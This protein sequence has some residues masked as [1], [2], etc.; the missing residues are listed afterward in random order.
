MAKKTII[1]FFRLKT[2][3][4]LLILFRLKLQI[5]NQFKVR[6]NKNKKIFILTNTVIYKKHQEQKQEI[7]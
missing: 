5:K 1:N 6:N 4:M 3:K 2:K 7:Y